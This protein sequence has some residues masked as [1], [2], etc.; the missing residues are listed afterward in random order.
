[1][2]DELP[3]TALS[4]PKRSSYDDDLPL[5]NLATGPAK[6]ARPPGAAK[7][8]SAGG[9]APRPAA[10]PGGGKGKGKGRPKKAES[11]SS[12]DSSDSSSSDS[13]SD[14]K[15]KKGAGGAKK[16]AVKVKLLNKKKNDA[17]DGDADA[18]DNK[19]KSKERSPKEQLVVDLLCRW[20]YV[21]PAWPPQDPAWYE[22]LLEARKLRRVEIQEWE[23][24]PDV[25]DKGREKVY[26][27]SQF[28]GLF[29][30]ADGTP[31]DL[32]PQDTIPSH[33]NFMRKETVELYSMLVMAYENQIKDLARSKYDERV[34]EG[35]LRSA[36]DKARGKLNAAK[37]MN[38]AKKQ[39]VE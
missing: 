34:L 35:T 38:G 15:K 17:D 22:P 2:D 32:R 18:A 25:D 28:R 4:K 8:P 14:A 5:A 19:I 11:S 3:L 1:M 36:L 21:I 24:V 30:K 10:S 13:S 12:S 20:W 33:N 27:L 6:K 9:T 31:V 39:R 29:R 16:K 7:P 23:W 26:E 37:E